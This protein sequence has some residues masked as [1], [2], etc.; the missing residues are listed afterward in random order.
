MKRVPSTAMNF[1][2]LVNRIRTERGLTS[3]VPGFDSKNGNEGAKYLFL[4][5]AP[6][7]RAK[8]TGQ[9]S[10]DN[11]DPS[12]RNLGAQ[13]KAAGLSHEEIALWNVV[14]WY[15]GNDAGTSIRAASANDVREG[16]K[17]LVELIE[18][19]P[20]LRCIILVGGAARKAHMYLSSKTTAR[21][22]TC[23]HTSARV[24]NSNPGAAE[25]NIAVF[26]YLKAST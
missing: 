16:L 20:N 11:P 26:R 23:H 22:L 17:Y 13:L 21:I 24:T 9:I 19:M 18:V 1:V 3:E 6:G 2:Y 14:P 12:A 7:P 15:I 10:V 4:L 5:E 8:E 25:E